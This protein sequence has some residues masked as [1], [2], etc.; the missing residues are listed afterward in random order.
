MSEGE[1]SKEHQQTHHLLHNRQLRIDGGGKGVDELGP[2]LVIHPQ[3]AA[4]LA[5]EVAL[6]GRAVFF[7]RVAIHDGVVDAGRESGQCTV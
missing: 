1:K 7:W 5:A 2:L 4:A 3:H 6:G